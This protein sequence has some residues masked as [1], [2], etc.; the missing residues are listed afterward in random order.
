MPADGMELT[1]NDTKTAVCIFALRRSGC[2]ASRT[3]LHN[4]ATKKDAH[5]RELGQPF[6]IGWAL[7]WGAYVA[8]YRC[9][10]DRLFANATEAGRLGREQVFPCS[11]RSSPRSSKGLRFCEAATGEMPSRHCKWASTD[12]KSPRRPDW[13]PPDLKSASR[14]W[15]GRAIPTRASPVPTSVWSRLSGLRMAPACWL[16][17]TLRLKGAG[18]DA[19]ASARGGSAASSL[20]SAAA[21]SGRNPGNCVARPRWRN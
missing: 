2:V 15:R 21:G 1:G 10:P 12:G 6:D 9:E 14:E 3:R 17:E 4:S 20:S 11:R 8:D 19:R 18:V 7:T 16:A 5:A 13:T